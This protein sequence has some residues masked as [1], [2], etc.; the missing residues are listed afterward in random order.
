MD[1]AEPEVLFRESQEGRFDVAHVWVQ[2]TKKYWT[3]HV[4]LQMI[5]MRIC[6]HTV[7]GLHSHRA[8]IQCSVSADYSELHIIIFLYEARYVLSCGC[9]VYSCRPRS[10]DAVTY[11]IFSSILLCA[12]KWL[13]GCYNLKYRAPCT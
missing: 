9:R 8:I 10:S 4:E 6:Y 13:N 7:T 11:V 1:M 2:F 12:R 5:V 3:Q